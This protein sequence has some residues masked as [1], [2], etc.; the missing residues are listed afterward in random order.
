MWI[1]SKTETELPIL[2]E[3]YTERPDPNLA[4]LR[5]DTDD[6]TWWKSRTDKH[7]PMRAKLYIERDEPSLIKLRSEIDDPTCM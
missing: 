2:I 6:D 3:P 5:Q 7:E 1:A 4:K